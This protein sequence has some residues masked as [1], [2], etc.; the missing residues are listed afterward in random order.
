MS[1]VSCCSYSTSA[2]LRKKADYLWDPGLFVPE[3]DHPA[4]DLRETVERAGAITEVSVG[5]HVS[6][7]MRSGHI[8]ELQHQRLQGRTMQASQGSTEKGTS[9]SGWSLNTVKLNPESRRNKGLLSSLV[10]PSEHRPTQR[11]L[12]SLQTD[13][14][15]PWPFW[16]E[17]H[18][19]SL[20]GGKRT[21]KQ[22]TV[23]GQGSEEKGG[24]WP[25]AF[26]AI[27]HSSKVTVRKP[28]LKDIL[29]K[30][31][32]TFTNRVKDMETR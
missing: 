20:L 7:L 31:K 21:P 11:V 2:D 30:S 19:L 8:D 29:Q 15:H 23:F 26:F 17:G 22:L 13:Q 5:V 28:I 32:S 10:N 1:R 18:L 27:I 3:G 24:K 14:C 9:G 25:S 6:G 4:E 12:S 16:S